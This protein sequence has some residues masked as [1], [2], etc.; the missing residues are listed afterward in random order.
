MAV[1]VIQGVGDRVDDAHYLGSRDSPGMDLRQQSGGIGAVDELHG[2][3]QAAVVIAAV[4]DGDDVRVVQGRH[5][6]GFLVEPL[7][8]LVIV[9]DLGAEHLEGVTPGQA[10]MLRQVDL[11][12]ATD[13]EGSLDG[14]AGEALAVR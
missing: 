4:V 9:T 12:H 5:H 6:L 8:V 3:P 14:V 7:P 10:R 2:D 13:T 1:R 11:A